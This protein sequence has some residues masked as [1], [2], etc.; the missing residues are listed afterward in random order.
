MEVYNYEK[1]IKNKEIQKV[2]KKYS[3]LNVSEGTYKTLLTKI[4]NCTENYQQKENYVKYVK[5]LLERKILKYVNSLLNNEEKAIELINNFVSLNFK[6]LNQYEDAINNITLMEECFINLNQEIIIKLIKNNET[7]NQNVKM[8]YEKNKKNIEKTGVERVFDNNF[9]QTLVSIYCMIN[10]LSMGYINEEINLNG[11]S[12]DIKVYLSQIANIPIATPEENVR[13]V[14]KAQ[15]GDIEARNRIIESNLR[16]IVFIARKYKCY[17]LTLMDLIQEGSLGLMRA[18]ELFKPEYGFAFSTYCYNWIRQAITRAIAD[19]ERQV[20]IPVHMVEKMNKYVQTENAFELK[21]GRKPT[22]EE[23]ANRMNISVEN[24]NF[25]KSLFLEDVSLNKYICKENND[26]E[27]GDLIPDEN[28]KVED[29]AVKLKMNELIE[30]IKPYLSEREL[31]VLLLR[32][33]YIDNEIWTLERIG[34][35]CGLTR[36]RIRQIEARAI[37]KVRVKCHNMLKDYSLNA[38]KVLK[39][40]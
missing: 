36:E 15:A 35:L 26:C 34:K 32:S 10:N 27:V 7:L 17:N 11:L 29:E 1:I 3:F 37:R 14:Q 22:I 5:A 28:V 33:G 25:V 9:K 21:H 40:Y 23:I 6:E 24:A 8:L 13:L 16:L 2:L 19:K 31:W 18:I 4:I 12:E 39:F 38:E 30:I 20:R